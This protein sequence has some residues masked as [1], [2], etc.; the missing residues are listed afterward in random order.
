MGILGSKKSY[1][2]IILAGGF[3]TRL[4]PVTKVYSKQLINIYDK[5]MV[6]YPLSTLMLM[7]IKDILIIS[8]PNN[9]NSYKKLFEDGSKLGLNIQYEIQ[10]NPNGIGEAFLIGMDF[11]GYDNVVLIL[12]DNLFYGDFDLFRQALK[13]HEKATIFAHYVNNPENYGI[14]EFDNNKKAISLEEKPRNPKSNYAIPG[15][16]IYD[17]S[18]IS[19][20]LGTPASKRMELEITDINNVYLETG[21]LKVEEIGR[22]MAWLDTGTPSGLLQASNFI[23]TIEERQGLKI[24]C[25]EEIAY[26]QKFITKDQLFNLL[27]LMPNNQY[28]EYLNKIYFR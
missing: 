19:V 18:I 5:P 23:S 25:I 24:G 13:E 20:A 14:V 12:G 6:Y 22:G 26:N 21:T 17:D 8:D 15:L 3:G 11:I 4:H 9:I 28:R 27:T 16:Y 7:G 1:K 2:G 10:K